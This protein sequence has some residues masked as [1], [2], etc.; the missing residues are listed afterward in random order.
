[1]LELNASIFGDA[2]PVCLGV[3]G[4]ALLLPGGDFLDE[5]QFVGNA[6][7]KALSGQN[8]EFGLC[9]IKATAVFG[10]LVHRFRNTDPILARRED[11]GF[12][13]GM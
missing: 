11:S 4:I 13:H 3:I 12:R 9:E 8:A 1:M 7:V 2:V 10:R 5:G 6:A